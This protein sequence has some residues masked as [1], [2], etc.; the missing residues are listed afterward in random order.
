[1]AIFNYSN[2]TFVAT[3]LAGI[4]GARLNKSCFS[5]TDSNRLIQEQKVSL[6]DNGFSNDDDL[7][8]MQIKNPDGS[9][10]AVLNTSKNLGLAPLL[11]QKVLPKDLN[12]L[13]TDSKNKLKPGLTVSFGEYPMMIADKETSKRLDEIGLLY[14]TGKTYTFNKIVAPYYEESN[15][16]HV[17]GCISN[18]RNFWGS[19]SPTAQLWYE[20]VPE[21]MYHGEKYVCVTARYV[22]DHELP[23]YWKKRVDVDRTSV[24]YEFL[25]SNGCPVLFNQN[26]WV[27]VDQ[28]EWKTGEFDLAPTKVL[29][30]GMPLGK[31]YDYTAQYTNEFIEKS[32]YKDILPSD[33][34]EVAKIQFK[35]ELKD[36]IKKNNA[37]SSSEWSWCV[38]QVIKSYKDIATKE[39]IYVLA[40]AS[41][42]FDLIQKGYFNKESLDQELKTPCL[43]K[44]PNGCLLFF[45]D[46]FSLSR[47]NIKY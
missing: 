30:G 22:L 23:D 14:P 7:L 1:M 17:A 47:Q 39:A 16:N 42:L 36:L 2:Q 10:T 8:S 35:D 28:V 41:Q 34:K 6:W 44:I 38:K 19:M 25:L 40:Y 45:K 13:L 26:Y 21:V 9:K 24:G 31:S 43:K 29:L 20:H 3:D 18:G 46:L 12:Q 4:L 5:K 33:A 32:F 27:K 37:E 11:D 15:R